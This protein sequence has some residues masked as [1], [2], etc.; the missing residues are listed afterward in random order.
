M[1][2][3]TFVG[4]AIIAAFAAT[5]AWAQEPPSASESGS[6]AS[7]PSALIGEALTVTITASVAS[8]AELPGWEAKDVKYTIPG[9]AVSVKMVGSEVAIVITVTPYKKK[10]GG[11]LLVA[12]GQVWYKDGDTGL[13]Y[14]TTID[15]LS[16]A[17]GERVLFYPFGAHTS[18]G[19]PLRVELIMDRYSADAAAAAKDKAAP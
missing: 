10:E 19:A 7:I 2:R 17:F 9:T 11:L 15:T 8:V 1:R 16:V 6:L 18:D 12:Q 13:R 14:R 4:A 3:G 5:S